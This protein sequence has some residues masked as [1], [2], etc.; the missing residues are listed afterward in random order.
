[1]AKYAQCSNIHRLLAIYNAICK[2][3]YKN[4]NYMFQLEIELSAIRID[5]DH[6]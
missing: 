6:T 1:M 5:V 2:A 3:Y 4:N